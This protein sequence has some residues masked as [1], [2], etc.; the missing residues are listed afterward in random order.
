MTKVD[1]W[2]SIN[3]MEALILSGSLKIYHLFSTVARPLAI[4]RGNVGKLSLSLKLVIILS[5][6]SLV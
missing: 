1:S 2:I 5:L 6:S 3:G 4:M